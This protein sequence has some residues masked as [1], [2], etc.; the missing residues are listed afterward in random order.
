MRFHPGL[1]AKASRGLLFGGAS[2]LVTALVG[3]AVWATV[4]KLDE[5]AQVRGA[6]AL[7]A[8]PDSDAWKVRE[9]LGDV[10]A[11]SGKTTPDPAVAPEDVPR[12]YDD[13]CQVQPGDTEVDTTCVLSLIHISEPTRPCGTSRMPSSA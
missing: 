2:M 8:D 9:D 12:Y 6:T 4:P 1:S 10:V 13:D 3:G 5:D 11:T 7:V